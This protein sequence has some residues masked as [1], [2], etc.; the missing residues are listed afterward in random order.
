MASKKSTWVLGIADRILPPAEIEAA[1]FPDAEIIHLSDWHDSDAAREEWKKVDALLAWNW[2]L[3]EETAELLERCKIV[4]RY[5]VGYDR[6][7][8]NALTAKGILFCNTPDY[9][10]EEVADTACALIMA[11]QRKTVALD[12]E[13]RFFEEGWQIN[14][15]KL[16]PIQRTSET[17]V[18]IIG[19]G[20]I[21]TAVVNRLKP[22]GCTVLGYDPYQP[23]GH[24]KAVGYSRTSTLEEM[25]EK[26]DIVSLNCPLTAETR[27]MVNDS[28]L[29]LMKNGSSIVNTARGAIVADLDCVEQALRSGKLASAALDVLPEE[30]PDMEHPL[31]KAWLEDQKWLRGRLIINPHAAYYSEKAYYE[32]RYKAAETARMFLVDEKL[33]NQITE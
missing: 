28:F 22:F 1:A 29:E 10:T 20:R 14:I 6:I 25:L 7:N 32:I 3:D 18:G 30:P 21:G 19:V 4:V 8:V 33:R 24:E 15:G 13:S 9:G 11:L 26:A 2:I 16:K 27:G 17:T 23:S 31:I 5:G 12:R